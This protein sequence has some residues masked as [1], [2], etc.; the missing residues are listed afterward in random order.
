[1]SSITVQDLP[2]KA[3]GKTSKVEF[4]LSFG[5]TGTATEWL[6]TSDLLT[7]HARNGLSGTMKT[8]PEMPVD[9]HCLIAALHKRIGVFADRVHNPGHVL[10]RVDGK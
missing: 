1:M 10:Y 2:Y 5:T 8:H 7:P 3:S 6:K 9:I 4:N